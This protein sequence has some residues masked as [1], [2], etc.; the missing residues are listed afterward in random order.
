M[1]AA[2]IVAVGLCL[3]PDPN[4]DKHGF[5]EPDAVM[6]TADYQQALAATQN[7]WVIDV[8]WIN[9]MNKLTD[10]PDD[11]TYEKL[12][13]E[14]HR[15]IAEGK[16]DD[17]EAD[18][19]RD[20]MDGPWYRLSRE[21]DDRMSGLSADL[22]MLQ[23]NEVYEPYEGTQEQLRS[24]LNA[25]WERGDYEA[26]LGFLRK[27]TPFLTPERVAYLRGRCY[28]AL[29]HLDT[30]LLFMRYASNRDPERAAYRV[31]ILDLLLSLQRLD[32]ARA[33]AQSFMRIADEP[34]SLA[35]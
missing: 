4:N 7:E 10:K 8:V 20:Q 22:Y 28:A 19:I 2:N 15:L 11:V 29:G 25:A 3:R 6:P 1:F 33:E 18:A 35:A 26:A 5:V 12:L 24:D 21:E 30:A 17:E 34:L 14:L 16:G 32:E 31:A 27:G 13:I 9:V 23:D